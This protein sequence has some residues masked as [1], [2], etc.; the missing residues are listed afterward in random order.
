MPKNKKGDKRIGAFAGSSGIIAIAGLHNACH[1][2][3]TGLIAFLAIFGIYLYGMP[4][5]FLQDYNL[6]FWAMA[7]GS[8]GL[9]LFIKSKG[10]CV[11]N[12]MLLFN[13]GVIIA[14]I[15]FG[16]TQDY[17]LLFGGILIIASIVIYIRGRLMLH[18]ERPG[19]RNGSRR[20]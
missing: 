16:F 11:S 6:Y 15:P 18:G 20:E 9:M 17:G 10:A 14:G 7:L 1:A 5:A 8:L 4:L 3:C 13:S 2:I 19:M 12:N